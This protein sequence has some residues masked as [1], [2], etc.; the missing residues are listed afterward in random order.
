[1]ACFGQVLR[2][3]R[4]RHLGGSVYLSE[5]GNRAGCVLGGIEA[6]EAIHSGALLFCTPLVL[7]WCVRGFWSP[8]VSSLAMNLIL[9]VYPILHLRLTRYRLQ[10]YAREAAAKL[11]LL[12]SKVQGAP[13]TIVE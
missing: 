6:D 9:N 2:R 1:M 11:D 8:V 10:R 12:H 3:T 13:I 7:I 5:C 4:L